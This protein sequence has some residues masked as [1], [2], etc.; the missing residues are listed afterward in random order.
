MFNPAEVKRMLLSDPRLF[1]MGEQAQ[2]ENI[3]SDPG[4][5]KLS[6]HYMTQVMGVKHSD[7]VRFPWALR[8]SVAMLRR[9]HEFLHR[10]GKAQYDE[11]LPGYVSPRRLLEQDDAL[12]ARDVCEV[13]LKDYHTFLKTL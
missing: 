4:A 3:A 1:M 8:C 12:F 2:H 6:H 5:L 9:R 13:P 11:E 10:L 7:L